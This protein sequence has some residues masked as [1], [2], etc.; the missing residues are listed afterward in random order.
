M[1]KHLTRRIAEALRT[2]IHNFYL[3]HSLLASVLGVASLVLFGTLSYEFVKPIVFPLS[4][5]W[6]SRLLAIVLNTLVVMILAFIILLKHQQ[7]LTHVAKENADRHSAEEESENH[8]RY[9]E[10]LLDTI[11]IPIFY[12]DTAGVFL[13]CNATFAAQ[14]FGVPKEQ[15]VGRTVY[16]F[17]S[18]IPE[19]L[20]EVYHEHDRRLF[21]Q[22]GT[23][24]Y[25]APVQC[26]DGMRREFVLYKAAFSDSA[27]RIA[28]VV[29]VML[30]ITNQKAAE[31]KLQDYRVHLEEIV[32]GRT[33]ELTKT[34]ELLAKEVVERQRFEEKIK[35]S[36]ANIKAIFD[37][38]PLSFVLIDVKY[39]IQECNNPAKRL[40][41]AILGKELRVGASVYAYIPE[42]AR[43]MF[44]EN[45]E[46][47]L[48]GSFVQSDQEIVGH[49]GQEYWFVVTYNPVMTEEGKVLGVCGSLQDISERKRTENA[50]RESEKRLKI[51]AEFTYDW[52]SWV[53][54][55][56]TYLYVSPSCERI[57]G[58]S[59]QQFMSSPSF[60]LKIVHPDDQETVVQ[61]FS[62]P[63][64]HKHVVSMDFRIITYQGDI[65]WIHH[66]C[67]AIYLQDGEYSGRRASN[68]D[69]TERKYAEDALRRERD[70]IQ[71]YLSVAEVMLI[72]IDS[73]QRVSLINKKGCEILGYAEDEI[74]GQNWFDCFLPEW[75]REEVRLGFFKL[76]QGEIASLEYHENPIVTHKGEERLIAWH[77]TLLIGKDGRITG[78][79]SSG[80]DIT[81][82]KLAERALKKTMRELERSNAELEQF[83]YAASHDLQQPLLMIECYAQLLAQRYA[84]SLD[85]DAQS[86]IVR[87]QEGVEWMQQMIKALLDYSRMEA[88]RVE[89]KPVDCQI[90]LRKALENLHTM[91]EEHKVVVTHDLLP[92]V[93]VIDVQFVQLLQNLISNAVKFR[94][95][96]QPEIRIAV[97]QDDNE[98][99]WIFSV[100]DN[101]I[102]IAPED[103]TRIFTIFERLHSRNKYPGTGIGLAIC[104]KI[105]ERHGGRI[106]V[107][108]S[109]GQGATFYFTHPIM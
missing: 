19:A 36:D 66:I 70:R 103:A 81:E 71:K 3:H 25:E 12:K 73:D 18:H 87:I 45:F 105:V 42:K 9:L 61:H 40:A 23:Q 79:L 38:S 107:R 27:D 85:E 93:M 5:I 37:N 14:I 39:T 96:V 31:T 63:L 102:G 22:G 78:T 84:E 43:A 52:E 56:G 7:W 86:F 69:I 64:H 72:V 54:P 80:E 10:V 34:N 44:A 75:N 33:L 21:S 57:S 76:L 48:Q 106:W 108:S 82:R 95:D 53:A 99:E 68:R 20:A 41:R 74:L 6:Q 94:S 13:G 16:D 4:G 67:Q 77:N 100:Q 1:K 24:I 65:R 50:R 2:L 29:G 92:T 89:L 28:G 62:D 98:H 26:A 8:S 11:P 15:I 88:K 35:H 101:G 55:D 104:K 32:R 49:D 91:L 83:A 60:F 47:A 97:V 51:I 17:S 59:P 30:D 109:P 46:Q 58:Y 90:L